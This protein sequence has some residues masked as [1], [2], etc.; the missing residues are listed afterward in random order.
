MV[1]RQPVALTVQV[2]S[3]REPHRVCEGR[4]SVENAETPLP[5]AGRWTGRTRDNTVREKRKQRKRCKTIHWFLPGTCTSVPSGGAWPAYNQVCRPSLTGTL[6]TLSSAS[7]ASNEGKP[8]KH[9]KV[10]RRFFAMGN[11]EPK[12]Q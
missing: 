7:G 11:A 3:R 1:W 5:D 6:R 8:K 12:S 4:V 10:L 2:C 9:R